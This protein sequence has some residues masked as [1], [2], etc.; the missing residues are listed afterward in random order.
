MSDTIQGG[1]ILSFQG[2]S[3]HYADSNDACVDSKEVFIHLELSTS[4]QK[5]ILPEVLESMVSCYMKVTA[6]NGRTTV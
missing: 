5:S 3:T 6:Q 1:G 4:V 2:I